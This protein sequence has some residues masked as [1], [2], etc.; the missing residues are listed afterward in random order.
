MAE[1]YLVGKDSLL[2]YRNYYKQ[3]KKHLHKWTK[4]EMPEWIK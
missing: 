2:S 4:R 3:G 1:E